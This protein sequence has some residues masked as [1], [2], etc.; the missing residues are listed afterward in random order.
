[1]GYARIA[2]FIILNPGKFQSKSIDIYWNFHSN[3]LDGQ[4]LPIAG[5]VISCNDFARVFQIESGIPAKYTVTPLEV[6]EKM[7]FTGKARFIFPF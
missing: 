7:S 5:D 6:F 2:A 1:M 4:S 3:F